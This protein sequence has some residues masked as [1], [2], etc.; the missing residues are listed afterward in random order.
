MLSV[1][2]F[3]KITTCSTFEDSFLGL[4]D[5][6]FPVELGNR[7]EKFGLGQLQLIHNLFCIDYITFRVGDI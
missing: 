3:S 5:D 6:P 2:I 1:M 7:V 4:V